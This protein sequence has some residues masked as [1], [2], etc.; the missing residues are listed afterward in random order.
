MLLGGERNLENL[1]ESHMDTG[2]HANLNIDIKPS[3]GSNQPGAVSWQCYL[4]YHDATPTII[5]TNTN[6]YI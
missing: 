5:I 6:K 3:S 1:E 4:L 2:E